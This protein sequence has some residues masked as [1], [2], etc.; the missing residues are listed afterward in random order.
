V[1]WDQ[2][3]KNVNDGKMAQTLPQTLPALCNLTQLPIGTHSDRHHLECVTSEY[4]GRTYYFDS[5]VSK[6]CFEQEPERYAGHLN[7]VDRFIAGMIQPA[8]LAGVLQ[9]MGL[10]EDVMG[11]DAGDYCWAA[12]YLH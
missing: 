1:F 7:V 8:D 11:D 5:E 4:R 10:T 9:W 3:I 2:I 12:E 6:W